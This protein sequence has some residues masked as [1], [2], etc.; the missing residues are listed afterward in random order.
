MTEEPRVLPLSELVG[1]LWCPECGGRTA[2]EGSAA[3]ADD[4]GIYA[5]MRV[6]ACGVCPY[7]KEL[8]YESLHG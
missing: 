6:R 5:V 8:F 3:I 7:Y 4:C 2:R 1:G